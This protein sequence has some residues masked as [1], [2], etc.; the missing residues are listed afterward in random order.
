M[1][2]IK[3]DVIRIMDIK[4]TSFPASPACIMYAKVRGKEKDQL[5]SQSFPYNVCSKTYHLM[6]PPA[7]T[8][9]PS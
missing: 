9:S 5:P 7:S 3:V 4:R 2:D 8:S 6:I 1:E